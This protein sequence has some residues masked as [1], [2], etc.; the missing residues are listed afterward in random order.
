MLACGGLTLCGQWERRLMSKVSCVCSGKAPKEPLRMAR[1]NCS[2]LFT[3]PYKREDPHAC[4]LG[5]HV[6]RGS[7]TIE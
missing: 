5:A 1:G 3:C 2:Q 6:V 4:M 7:L